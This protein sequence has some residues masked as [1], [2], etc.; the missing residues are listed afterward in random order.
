MHN[1]NIAIGQRDLRR[2]FIQVSLH[3]ITIIGLK[4][5]ELD[6]LIGAQWWQLHIRCHDIAV[7]L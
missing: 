3:I 2:F 6:L 4:I 1:L 7:D 5:Q